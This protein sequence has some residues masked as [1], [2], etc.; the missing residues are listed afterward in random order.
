MNQNAFVTRRWFIGGA[1]SFGAFQGC[2]FAE[3]PFGRSGVARLKLGVVSDIHVLAENTDRATAGNT[4]TFRRALSWF[5]GQGVDAVIVAGDMADAG[6]ISQLQC[7]ADAW[8][9]VFPNG[10]SSLDGR[11]VERCFVYGNHDWEGFIYNYRIFGVESKNLYRDH[12]REN[13]M[14]RTWEEVFE[15]EYQPIYRKDIKGYTFVGGHWDGANG[16]GLD[17]GPDI[18]DFFAAHGKT[19]DPRLPFF[20]FQHPV[21][22]DTCY[23]SWSWGQ[24]AGVSTRVLSGYSN[25]IAFS[26]HTHYSLLDERF[27]WQGAFTSIGA[28]SLRYA[29]NPSN[30]TADRGGYENVPDWGNKRE[31]ST[32]RLMDFISADTCRSGQLVSVYDDHVTLTRRDF[33]SGLDLG[34]DLVMPLPVAEEKPFAF[35]ERAKKF[36]APSFAVDAAIKV[37]R[38]KR[39]FT[40]G[41]VEQEVKVFNLIVPLAKQTFA[42]RVYRYEVRAET[43]ADAKVVLARHVLAPDY[44]LPL[45]KAPAEFTV[46]VP[47]GDLPATGE[48]RFVVVPLNCFGKA[49]EPIVTEY[50]SLSAVKS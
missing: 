15:E 29:G 50:L 1:A 19:I 36:P 3:S 2:R 20:Y 14:K 7:V 26:G 37:E 12:I 22:K 4:R 16:S 21:P 6:L 44:H 10:R 42:N 13:G 41:G 34:P 17:K 28:G 30:E 18:A 25:V 31:G 33:L 24:D 23:G 27:I 45:A 32:P 35:V 47:D 49:G 43:K 38:G 48:F 5:D 8:N 46:P 11:K 39:K 40:K 9:A